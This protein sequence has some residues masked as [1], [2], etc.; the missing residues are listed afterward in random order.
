MSNYIKTY[1]LKCTEVELHDLVH[2][3]PQ[4]TKEDYNALKLSLAQH[5][6]EQPIVMYR[7]KCI[8][9]RHRLKALIELGEPEVICRNEQSN[10]SEIDITSKVLDVHECR[11]HQTQTQKAIGA[12]KKYNML[13]LNGEQPAKGTIAEQSGVS[14]NT[15]YLA[16]QLMTVCGADIV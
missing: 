13:V 3:T 8:D 12:L 5:G 7:G 6:Q 2:L 14:R 9:G 11:R 1:K 4:M 16:E 10:L 15:L